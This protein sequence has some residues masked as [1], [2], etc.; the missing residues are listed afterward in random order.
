MIL[1]GVRGHL[2]DLLTWL[3]EADDGHVAPIA[4][5]CVPAFAYRLSCVQPSESGTVA[6]RVTIASASDQAVLAG[7]GTRD[8]ASGSATGG[9]YRGHRGSR[10]A[11]ISP[12][13]PK[14]S[15]APLMHG[16]E[17]GAASH[18]TGFPQLPGG[19]RPFSPDASSNGARH[20]IR[21]RAAGMPCRRSERRGENLWVI[22]DPGLQP[23]ETNIAGR[24]RLL[25]GAGSS[26]VPVSTPPE[27]RL[28]TTAITERA[29]VAR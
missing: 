9:A 6:N 20:S 29:G 15:T 26:L 7:G 22:R 14:C 18:R 16:V 25:G 10:I 13:S 17:T 24:P 4:V 1:N 28:E 19:G 5:R 23:V 21:D 2:A 11:S 3:Q 12:D 8:G 27:T